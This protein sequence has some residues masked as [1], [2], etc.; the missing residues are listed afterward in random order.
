MRLDI[1]NNREITLNK[2]QLTEIIEAIIDYVEGNGLDK[3]KT[4]EQ[5]DYFTCT[6]YNWFIKKYLKKRINVEKETQVLDLE[7]KRLQRKRDN[8]ELLNN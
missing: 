2:S 5:Q 7:I 6:L 8:L 4:E 1:F 3:L